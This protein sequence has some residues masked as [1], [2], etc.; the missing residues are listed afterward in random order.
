MEASTTKHQDQD[1]IISL[2]EK[3]ITRFSI[4]QT[5]ISDNGLTFLG[6]KVTKFT[7]KYGIYW[8][9]SSRYYTYGNGLA[10]SMNKKLLRILKWEIAENQ[11]D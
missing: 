1:T 9:I 3:I 8:K 2:M 11:K 6:A 5:I 10:K 4:L 7:L